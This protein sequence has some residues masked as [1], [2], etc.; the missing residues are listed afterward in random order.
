[1]NN[2]SGLMALYQNLS[3]QKSMSIEIQRNGQAQP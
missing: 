2:P 3:E 1:V